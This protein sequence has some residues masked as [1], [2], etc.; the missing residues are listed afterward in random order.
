[1]PDQ[2]L[3][4]AMQEVKAILAKHD[5]AGVI[6]LQSATHAEF[7]YHFNASWSCVRLE[8]DGKCRFKSKLA[9][10]PDRQTQKEAAEASLGT[11]VG[12]GHLGKKLAGDMDSI[13][14]MIGKHF[15]FTNIIREE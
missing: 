8:E 5:I 15:E 1:M 10:Y 7:L 2:K 11:L 14:S 3:K 13:C 9:D 6:F 4:V 12:F